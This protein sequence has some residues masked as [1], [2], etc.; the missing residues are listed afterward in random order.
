MAD[1]LATPSADH[2]RAIR[3]AATC[4]PLSSFGSK[5]V[6]F[7]RKELDD[8]EADSGRLAGPAKDLLEWVSSEALENMTS[9]QYYF[10]YGHM[11]L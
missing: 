4:A 8:A 2:I 6:G 10:V 5:F 1:P 11:I 7:F 3:L 9:R